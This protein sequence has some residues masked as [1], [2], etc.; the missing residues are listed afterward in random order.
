M[1]VGYD[2]GSMR[3][4]FIQNLL[5]GLTKKF[6]VFFLHLEPMTVLRALLFGPMEPMTVLRVLLV[7]DGAFYFMMEAVSFIWLD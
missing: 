1:L 3:A 6:L 7:V 4:L 5:L 2:S